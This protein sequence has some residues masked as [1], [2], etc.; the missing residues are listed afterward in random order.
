[1]TA[2]T[3]PTP[4]EEKDVS[5]CYCVCHS[6]VSSCP[7]CVHCNSQYLRGLQD[8]EK[9]TQEVLQ[10]LLDELPKKVADN[11]GN[12]DGDVDWGKRIGQNRTIDL[13]TQL[14]KKKVQ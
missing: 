8:G 9:R 10:E 12:S 13:V 2:H 3:N 5:E 11:I 7:S 14:I 4:S 6:S 1:M